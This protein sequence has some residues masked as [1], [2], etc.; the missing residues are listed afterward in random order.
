MTPTVITGVCRGATG[1]FTL[2]E[3]GPVD[4]VLTVGTGTTRYCG[5]CGG[6]AQGDPATVFK[7]KGCGTPAACP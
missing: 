3:A 5:R 7:H 1:T 4:I 2:P 6:T